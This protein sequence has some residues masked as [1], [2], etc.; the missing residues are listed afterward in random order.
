MSVTYEMV[1]S[2]IKLVCLEADVIN[3]FEL[4]VTKYTLQVIKFSV[5]LNKVK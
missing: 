4:S 5:W 2:K 1:A 3:K